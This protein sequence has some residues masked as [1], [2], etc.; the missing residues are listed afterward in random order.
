MAKKSLLEL[1]DVQRNKVKVNNAIDYEVF[2]DNLLLQS[3]RNKVIQKL[4][5]LDITS[6]NYSEKDMNKLVDEY[7]LKDLER[8]Y[9]YNIVDN[10]INHFGPLSEI[11]DY[12]NVD[13]IMVNSKDE[14]YVEIEGKISKAENISFISD[15]HIIKLIERLIKPLGKN[16]DDSII[17]VRLN[18]GYKLN[19]ILPPV[20]KSGP[21]LTI[22]KMVNNAPNIDEMM[23]IGTLTPYM[24]RFLEAAILSKLN[25][26]ICGNSGS[27]KTS[28]LN[29]L[30]SLVPPNERI[31][32]VE[33][34][35]E[36]SINNNH[37]IYLETN[38][39]TSNGISAK[40]LVENSLHMRPDRL[41]VGE[42]KGD[43][44]FSVIQA[45]NIGIE[46]LV[47]TMYANSP[48][49]ALRRLETN[50]LMNGKEISKEV[51]REYILNTVDLIV[52]IERLSDGRRK[53]INISEIVDVNENGFK[54]QEIFAFLKQ[55]LTDKDFVMGEFVLYK[56]IP[57]SYKKMKTR[58]IDTLKDIFGE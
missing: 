48:I 21:I 3:V 41:V 30:L 52:H 51:I 57:I 19:A 46:G 36:L 45:L 12:N 56:H 1:F 5:D 49:D 32:V 27:G 55:G 6:G 47:T 14:I 29:A 38:N 35:E 58:G 23:R 20:A 54:M 15:E 22:K 9:I 53:I 39:D 34:N 2:G 11:L 28:L 13:E 43:E 16:I 24:A 31:V 40:E 8:S 4:I 26:I 42:I 37:V 10:E 7:N 18:N 17:N 25:I 50:V 44:A 33:D